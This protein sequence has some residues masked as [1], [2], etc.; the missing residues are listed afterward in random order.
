[1]PV[2]AAMTLVSW[3]ASIGL[4]VRVVHGRGILQRLSRLVVA[5]AC[6]LVASLFTALLILLHAFGAF[7]G[8]TLIA[9]VTTQPVA[10]DEFALTYQPAQGV[11]TSARTFRLRG[12]QWA[13][14]GGIVTWH[15]W[16][17]VLG[18]PSYHKPLRLS[19]QFSRIAQQRS[20]LPTAELLEPGVDQLWE[21]FYRA[22]PYLPF[23]EA[24]YGSSAYVYV[25]PQWIQA[26]YVT[27]S[28]YLIKRKLRYF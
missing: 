24:V 11:A 20:H 25:E 16:L 26:I 15:P 3:L 13:I 12:N 22:D 18:F 8:E 27:P 21:W 4:L 5:L 23:V 19:G 6:T 1:M 2:V 17:T 14:S 10:Q 9:T 28:G 7:A